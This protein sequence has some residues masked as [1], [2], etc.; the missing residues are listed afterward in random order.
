[1]PWLL[2]PVCSQD[3]NVV[4]HVDSINKHWRTDMTHCPVHPQ[5]PASII[6]SQIIKGSISSQR[7]RRHKRNASTTWGTMALWGRKT[8]SIWLSAECCIFTAINFRMV[9]ANFIE[10]INETHSWECYVSRPSASHFLNSNQYLE[11]SQ[12]FSLHGTKKH[13]REA[14]CMLRH[15][16]QTHLFAIVISQL[17]T[18][19]II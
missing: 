2:L 10:F 4:V 11:S 1:M 3:A 19:E 14:M 6:H 16:H 17:I 5:A 7:R 18:A 8:G 12:P 13:S 15:F 9:S